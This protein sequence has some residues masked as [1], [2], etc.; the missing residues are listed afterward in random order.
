[1]ADSNR[2]TLQPTLTELIRF[3]GFATHLAATGRATRTIKSYRSDWI[4][5]VRWCAARGTPF[6]LPAFGANLLRTWRGE[7]HRDGAQTSTINRKLVF[8]KR[9]AD[10]AGRAGVL[11]DAD[12]RALRG[13]DPVPQPRRQPRQLNDL[14]RQRLIRE[15]ERRAT[16]RDRAIIL[17]MLQSG[18]R[19]G[20]LV[21][22][23]RADVTLGNRGGHLTV[24]AANGAE[25]V[26]PVGARAVSA[27][28]R[29]LEQRG[30]ARGPLFQGERGPLTA[31]GVQRLVRKYCGNVGIEATPGVLRHTFASGFLAHRPGDT[32]G[33]ADALG[34]E[35]LDAVRLY[36]L[37]APGADPLHEVSE[38]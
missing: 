36:S 26:V 1:M 14:E 20:E 9:Y 23:T 12:A 38:G 8:V 7:Q 6:D 33:L 18:V 11:E 19:V 21:A 17:T 31:N 29:Y 22:L 4:G 34:H 5:F 13:I 10:W 27:L 15:V 32:V 37:R 25:R 30:E 3:E 28:R 16:A 2:P 24:A 35:T